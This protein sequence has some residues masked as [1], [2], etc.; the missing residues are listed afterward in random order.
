VPG[1]WVTVRSCGWLQE[2]H[3]IASVLHAEGIPVLIPDE[4]TIGVRPEL[5]LALGGVRVMVPESEMQRALATLAAVDQAT[6]GEPA[7]DEE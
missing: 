1:E 2:A 7:E 4:H 3:F 6:A 5:A